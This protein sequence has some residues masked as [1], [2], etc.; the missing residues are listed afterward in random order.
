VSGIKA[1]EQVVTA[2]QNK[3]DQGSRV[4]IDNSIALNRVD[5]PTLQ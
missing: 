1:G 2:G 3:V 4:V 5:G